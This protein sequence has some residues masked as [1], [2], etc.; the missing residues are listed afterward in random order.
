MLHTC[1][2]AGKR[3]LRGD[4]SAGGRVRP[5]DARSRWKRRIRP[6]TILVTVMLANNEIGTVEPIARDRRSLPR[7]T[8]VLFHTDAVQAVGPSAHRR[9]SH[10]HRHALALRPQVPRP[11]GRRRAVYPQRRA[12]A[13]PDR[14]RRTGARPARRHREPGRH[15]RAWAQPSSWPS[16]K[17]WRRRA[18]HDRAAGQAHPT[19]FSTRFPKCRLNGHRHQAPARQRA[20]SRF[21]RY[22][23]RIA[24]AARWI[25][26]G[27]AAS[28][29]SACTSGSLDPSRMFCWP[30]ACRMRS[31]TVR[32]GLSL[33][34]HN[35]DGG[36]DR[37]SSLEQLPEIVERLRAMSPAVRRLATIK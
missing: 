14:G 11:Q 6:D 17:C 35:T 31:P 34:R 2:R 27:I 23:G 4:L 22:R 33:G 8:G 3:G 9:Q 16:R 37:L 20:T 12:A 18:A 21:A 1:A 19:A 32:C 36:A 7:S 13:Q 24:A 25:M 28:S 29:G 5:G 10:E 15:R 30:S 26:A